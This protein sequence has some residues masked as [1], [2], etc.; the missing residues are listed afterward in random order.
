[1]SQAFILPE[2]A[3]TLLQA[4]LNLN[5][6]F[7]HTLRSAYRS[8]QIMFALTV[9]RGEQISITVELGGQRHSTSLPDNS[10]HSAC[11]LADFIDAI[12]NGRID[13]A[14]IAPPAQLPGGDC[15]LSEESLDQTLHQLVKQ[16]GFA[17]VEGS[18]HA[19]IQLAVHT[20]LNRPGI[21]VIIRCGAES[22]CWTAYGTPARCHRLLL[23][24]LDWLASRQIAA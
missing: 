23:Q 10:K 21:T 7:T 22:R 2:H 17:T 14:A 16:G 3:L 13:S 20:T 11:L 15:Q 8:Q 5:G 9:E 24:S 1:M 12:A 19:P 18:D 4:Q 6:R